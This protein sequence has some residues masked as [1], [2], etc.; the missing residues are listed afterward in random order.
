[1]FAQMD[2]VLDVAFAVIIAGMGLAGK[3]ELDGPR[4]ITRKAD[5]VLELLEDQ[6]RTL[7]G[8][9]APGKSD[10]QRV[11]IQQLV[12]RDE[13]A[14]GMALNG[15]MQ[16]PTRKL[17]QLPAQFVT[18]GPDLL[19]RDE[20]RVGHLLP[21]IRRIDG[22]V[23]TG[24]GSLGPKSRRVTRGKLGWQLPLPSRQ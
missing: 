23:P 2:D 20:S 24:P 17:D 9:K 4:T 22:S 7:V 21:E 6:W 8:R 1:V 19:I 11:G 3:N 13:I 18:E 14:L 15:R 12:K 10:G 16:S 5:D